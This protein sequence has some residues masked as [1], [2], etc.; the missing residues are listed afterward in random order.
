[1]LYVAPII[2]LF[3]YLAF[4]IPLEKEVVLNPIVVKDSDGKFSN[5]IIELQKNS[6]YSVSL[7][8]FPYGYVQVDEWDFVQNP[9]NATIKVEWKTNELG[10][11]NIYLG[12]SGGSGWVEFGPYN[13]SLDIFKTSISVPDHFVQN[14]SLLKFRFRG[15]DLDFGP[16]AIAWV[17]VEMAVR[18]SVNGIIS[19]WRD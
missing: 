13:Q 12:Y 6:E 10:A 17:K 16:D 4:F 11:G 2:I 18:K 5:D 8:T 1:M 7:K 15:E 9:R 3:V 14:V 19:F